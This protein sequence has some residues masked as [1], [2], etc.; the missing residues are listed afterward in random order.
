MRHV[1]IARAR[2]QDLRK[3]LRHKLIFTSLFL[4]KD[5]L[6]RKSP[7]SELAQALKQHILFKPRYQAMKV[8]YKQQ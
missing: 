5:G 1:D 4:R 8:K 6:L 3:L 7:K 2:N